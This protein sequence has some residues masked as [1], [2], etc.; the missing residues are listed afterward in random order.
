MKNIIITENQLRLITE[1]LGVPDSILDA[2]E[3]IYDLIGENL[4]SITTKEPIYEFTNDVDIVLGDK[5]K[6]KIDGYELTVNVEE[7]PTQITGKPVIISMGMSQSFRFDRKVMMK[8]IERSTTAEMEITFG[9]GKEWEPGD[10]YEV[11]M[12]E[13]VEHLSSIAHEL[14]HKY[15]KQSK[16]LD[17]VGRDAEYNATQSYGSFGIPTIDQKFMRYLYYI[18]IAENLVRAT[19]VSSE[20]RSKNITKSKFNDFLMGN[21]VY[22]ELVEIKNFTFSD[23]I[24]GI[25]GDMDRVDEL[26]KH[27]GEDPENYTENQKIRKILEIVYI[28]LVNTKMDLFSRMTFDESDSLISLFSNVMGRQLGDDEM[29]KVRG[30]FQNHVTKYKGDYIQFFK[31]EIENFNY[32]GTK[33]LKKIGKL[34]AMAK[35]DQP[36]SESIINWELHQELMDKKYGKRRIDTEFKFKM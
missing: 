1:A 25:K 14:K 10:L 11:Y 34:Y 19:E 9:V 7:F 15:D 23:F 8:R 5:K 27:I 26:L 28:T 6:I 32:I 36:V 17:L 18:S 33:M 12:S 31:D 2:A 24:N 29:S 30:K 3:E 35:D 20:M 22:R 21:R 16:E 4:K 13:K